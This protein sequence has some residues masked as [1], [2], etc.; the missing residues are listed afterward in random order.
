[1]NEFITLFT[2]LQYTFVHSGQRPTLLI[3]STKSSRK[4]KL[5][6]SST[7]QHPES[8]QLL[9]PSIAPNVS[10]HPAGP[11]HPA[12][13]RHLLYSGWS[14]LPTLQAL[15]AGIPVYHE[16][17]SGSVERGKGGRRRNPVNS[18]QLR[19]LSYFIKQGRSPR[20]KHSFLPLPIYF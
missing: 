15:G 14:A 6:A 20:A 2:H 16:G 8:R 12:A 9:I 7:V 5:R 3:P 13:K 10:H 18:R 17:L 11:N 19:H 1:M 4:L